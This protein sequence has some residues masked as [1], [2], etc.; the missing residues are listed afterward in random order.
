MR[1]ESDMLFLVMSLL[2]WT[3]TEGSC[4]ETSLTFY[5]DNTLYAGDSFKLAC[6][7]KCLEPQHVAQLWKNRG[8]ENGVC[9]VN[10]S[11]IQ[12]NMTVVLHINS[13]TK[14]DTGYYSCM[15]QPAET[16][17]QIY[18]EI[19]EGTRHNTTRDQSNFT[20]S[21]LTT[22]SMPLCNSTQQYSAAGVQGQVWYWTLLGKTF[23]LLFSL[24][25]LAVKY[26]R[27]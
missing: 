9:Q 7:F 20:A 26:I 25:S 17:S 4:S 16:F 3:Q 13:V 14:A 24:A 5:G 23:I 6:E 21:T 15:T 18:I 19:V 12:P 22:L 10:V 8:Y 1:K 2:Y 11:S 27:G